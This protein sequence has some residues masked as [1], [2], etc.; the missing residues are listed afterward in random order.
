MAQQQVTFADKNNSLPNTDVR[1]LVRDDDVNELK[2]IVNENADDVTSSVSSL[3]SGLALKANIASPTFTGTVG[4][5]TKSMVGLGNVDNTSDT[6]KPVSTAQQ[7]A[8]DLKANLA[9][10]TFTGTVGGI[11]KSMVGLGNVDNTTDAGKPVSTAQQTALDLKLTISKIKR[12]IIPTG[13]V[14]GSNLIYTLPDSGAYNLC[15]Y[16]DTSRLTPTVG[17]TQSGTT[18]TIIDF[19]PASSI[20]CDYEIP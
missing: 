1:K 13:L 6:A 10:P 18:L 17:F 19:A 12:N 15:V 16:V 20:L 5:I 3:N 4:G 11:T 7:T 2:E 8:L 9:S 14:N